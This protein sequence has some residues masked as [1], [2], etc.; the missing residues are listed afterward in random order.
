[1][2]SN[3]QKFDVP[4]TIRDIKG[5][6]Y[7]AVGSFDIYGKTYYICPIEI[8]GSIIVRVINV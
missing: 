4:K 7:N 3:Q 5:T 1:M 8:C 6:E 2:L